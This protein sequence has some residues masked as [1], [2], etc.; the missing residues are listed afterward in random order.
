MSI[1]PSC[2]CPCQESHKYCPS[3]GFPIGEVGNSQDRLIGSILPG[4]YVILELIGVGGMGRVYRAEQ[5]A[6][7]RTV[8]V[9]VIHSHLLGDESTALRFITEARASSRL[10][11]PNSV[12][13]IDFGK[14]ND[15]QLYLVL[16]F[17][18]GHDLARVIYENGPLAMERVVD[19]TRQ[20]LGALGEAHDLGIIHRDLK[21]ENV[22]LEPRRGGGD[23]VKVVDFG[24]AKMVEEVN[25]STS[26]TRPGIV[27]GT[28]DY[29]APEQGR[30]EP[31]DG[32]TDLYSVGVML[33]VLLA[34]RLP[35]EADSPTQVVL[36]HLT[37]SP[38]DPRAVAPERNIPDGLADICLKALA[39][40]P[41]QRFQSADEFASALSD[42]LETIETQERRSQTNLALCPHCNMGNPEGHRFCGHC[43]K[44]MRP[45]SRGESFSWA[46]NEGRTSRRLRISSLPGFPLPLTSRDDD[47]AWLRD[48]LEEVGG[49]MVGARLVAE[50]GTGKSR[51]FRELSAE[52]ETQSMPV[53]WVGPDPWLADV[54]YWALR[55][56]IAGLTGLPDSGGEIRDWVGA[57]NE[58]RQGLIQV[59][60]K[61]KAVSMQ[62]AVTA[63][64]RFLAA[65]ALRWALLRSNQLGNHKKLVIL[66]DDLHRV[67]GASRNAF[68]DVIGD[69]PEVPVLF[70][71]AH[72]PG[73]EFQWGAQTSARVLRNLPPDVAA[74]LG[75]AKTLPE[76]E[77]P[78]SSSQT[79]G[80][81]P[82]YV[83]QLLRFLMDGGNEAPPRLADLIADRIERLH[84]ESK[85]VLQALAVLG[86]EAKFDE[87]SQML[88]KATNIESQ[89]DVLVN[90]DFVFI[91]EVQKAI[92][93]SHPLFR[94]VV[95]VM[96]PSEVRRQ[97]HQRAVAVSEQFG[98]P[99]EVRAMHAAE[100][101]DAFEALIL[102]EQVGSRCESRGDIAGSVLALRRALEVARR[103]FF[104]GE[105][106]DP[107]RAVL[108]FSRKLGDA[109]IR[110]GNFTDA[111]GVLRE[112]LDLA[113][114][115]GSDR[116]HVLAT[117][118]KVALGRDRQ[119]ES[120][121]FLNQAIDEANRSGEREL[122]SQLEIKRSELS[123]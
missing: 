97:M 116:A 123:N 109:L 49:S 50:E 70:L 64:H 26:I 52:V 76:I 108:I 2:G 77:P 10:N 112:A 68:A 8:A 87:L 73:H 13:V 32:R 34:H 21:P 17:L 56:L 95:N 1:C 40:D 58:A 44:N 71:A 94:E 102:L 24:L 20:V 29:M 38:P 59:F 36:M 41:S 75:K 105:L 57:S 98:H 39:K 104:R 111:D 12:S 89:V 84:P 27:C 67:D 99:L 4:G 11:H 79:M 103:E 82:M 81:P 15:G 37:M 51:L 83:D 113:G 35:F 121:H 96:I 69:P 6:L 47:L 115:S 18:R 88:P 3:C 78:S 22:I 62:S 85:T 61:A 30:G 25:Q 65:E 53:I 48:R 19:V 66:V 106:D 117:L 122:A 14:T 46:P 74:K 45:D 72:V 54:G 23:L 120:F 33:F 92:R 119:A 63:N 80:V 16:E 118:A 93:L 31:I 100:A 5:K 101:Q 55:K 7:G 9:K 86:N 28:P 43:G 114:P 91:D 60:G 42:A 107:A 90:E 110:M